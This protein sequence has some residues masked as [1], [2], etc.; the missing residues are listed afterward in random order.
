MKRLAI[1]TTHPIQ[2]NAPIFRILHQRGNIA[3]KV[4]YTWEKG[5][6]EFDRDFGKK[7]TWD[8]P[9][10]E[11]YDYEFS[12]NNGSQRRDFRG[13]Q[14]PG[15]VKAIEDWGAEAVLVIGWNY[16]SHLRVMRHF[17]GRIPVLFRGDST[18]LGE[19]NGWKKIARRLFLRWI[20]RHVDIA[21]Y[22]G[23][24][25]K[26]YFRAH[27]LKERQ[28]VFAPHAIDNR[29]FG[30]D[31]FEKTAADRRAALG[32]GKD[33]LLFVFVGKFQ[34]QKDPVTLVE[35]WRGIPEND[36]HLLMVGNG[37]LEEAVRSAADGDARVHFL[38]FQNQ[39]VMPEIYRI[40]DVYCLPS[41]SETWGLAVNEAM[42][43]SRAI[44]ASDLCGCSPDLVRNGTNGFI[45]AAGSKE[46]LCA[47]VRLFREN[48]QR[49]GEMGSASAS[50][51]R[52]WSYDSMAAA[53]EKALAG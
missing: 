33:Q 44:L 4:F 15:Q 22:V 8:I 37:E 36:V 28:L 40:G 43:C 23:S 27:G 31:E 29:R 49:L 18:L 50:I 3:I 14:N 17:K 11:G 5:S 24:R 38:G 34:W 35:A 19:Q 1:I 25:N 53:I 47:K 41:V 48:R 26:D 21:F 45:F 46:D 13:V 39:S 7:I 42:A 51:I 20:Y 12:S 10:L 16:A 32:I 30:N 6:E 9:L 2:Y 52:D